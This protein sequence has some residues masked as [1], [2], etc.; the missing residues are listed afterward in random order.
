MGDIYKN[1]VLTI[2]ALST[3]S[4]TE[5]FLRVPRQG[6]K[7]CEIP[8]PLGSSDNIGE[9]P[10]TIKGPDFNMIDTPLCR[11]GCTFQELFLSH[12]TLMYMADQ[13]LWQ[14]VGEGLQPVTTNTVK[15]YRD[16]FE[17]ILSPSPQAANTVL[18]G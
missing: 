9:I 5:G 10:L 3:R 18:E 6:P 12:R 13:L 1:A 14:S 7:S 16:G 8:F 17:S 2:A 11:R 4:T 15:S